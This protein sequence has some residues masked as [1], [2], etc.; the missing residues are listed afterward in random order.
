MCLCG[1]AARHGRRA[2]EDGR[3]VRDAAETPPQ[4]RREWRAW[5]RGNV[6]QHFGLWAW[7]DST[8]FSLLPRSRSGWS[9]P[10]TAS[11]RWLYLVMYRAAPRD[12]EGRVRHIC[13]E[14][15]T[16]AEHPASA[17]RKHSGDPRRLRLP[18]V[19]VRLS[20]TIRPSPVRPRRSGEMRCETGGGVGPLFRLAD[21]TRARAGCSHHTAQLCMRY[22]MR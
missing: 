15:D 5:G 18:S 8:C 4:V 17:Q 12:V 9:R 22:M 14:G 19:R 3:T 1:R 10:A 6:Q 21:G 11:G 2:R 13:T 7:L 16:R 20:C